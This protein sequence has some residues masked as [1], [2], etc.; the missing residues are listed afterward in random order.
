[1]TLGRF[2]S[3]LCHL[4]HG[5]V[6]IVGKFEHYYFEY[7]RKW[8]LM[9]NKDYA[10]YGLFFSVKDLNIGIYCSF[11]NRLLRLMSEF[12]VFPTLPFLF[13]IQNIFG[14]LHQLNRCFPCRI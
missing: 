4:R 2:T 11:S 12:A 5:F 10:V 8:F 7:G 14:D 1:M 3:A 13:R 6:I 9:Q